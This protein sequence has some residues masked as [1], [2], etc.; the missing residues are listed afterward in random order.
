MV[1]VFIAYTVA[2]IRSHFYRSTNGVVANDLAGEVGLEITQFG[3]I[4]NAF[5]IKLRL[6]QLPIDTGLDGFGGHIVAASVLLIV[7]AGSILFA[8]LTTM[9]MVQ[10][11]NVHSWRIVCV[12][13]R[14]IR[15]L[16]RYE[17][18]WRVAS[19]NLYGFGALLST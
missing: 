15:L 8:V 7:V 17:R 11:N 5:L 9:L 6:S 13:G 10:V 4:I 12:W 19:L 3:F 18:F 14:R 16:A 2:Y 1:W